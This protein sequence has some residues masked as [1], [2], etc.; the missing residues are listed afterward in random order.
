MPP[1]PTTEIYVCGTFGPAV[2]VFFNTK[3]WQTNADDEQTLLRLNFQK[4]FTYVR[5]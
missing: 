5:R 3:S 4:M 1:F 2:P